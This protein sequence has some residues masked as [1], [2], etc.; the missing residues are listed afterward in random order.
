M[1]KI[2]IVKPIMRDK[3]GEIRNDVV[4]GL[5]DKRRT[6]LECVQL[7]EFVWYFLRSTDQFAARIPEQIQFDGPD[8]Y[9]PGHSWIELEKA[10]SDWKLQL[11]G[12]LDINQCSFHET[13]GWIRLNLLNDSKKVAGTNGEEE[14]RLYFHGD[15]INL[16]E[17][18]MRIISSLFQSF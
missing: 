8:A 1:E 9:E 5:H 11:R 12:K 10:D 7:V 3:L 15:I 16:D 13:L 18:G 6:K 17:V 2:D 4:H 14:S